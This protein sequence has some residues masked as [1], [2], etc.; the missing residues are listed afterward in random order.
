MKSGYKQGLIYLLVGFALFNTVWQIAAMIFN[1][2]ALP[3]PWKVY[4]GYKK[5]IDSGILMHTVYSLSRVAAGLTVSLIIGA[6]VGVA[7]GYSPRINKLLWPV[8]YLSYPVPKLALLPVI[9][10]FLGIGEAAKIAVIVLIIVFQLIISI[11]DAVQAIPDDKYDVF[12]SL[13]ASTGDMICHITLPAAVPAILSSLRVSAGIAISVLIVAETYGT[14]YGL[15]FYVIDSWMRADYVQ[16]YFG[17]FVLSIIGLTIFIL[18][19]LSEKYICR[20]KR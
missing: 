10:I 2:N 6:A 13:G 20:W 18:L 15:G 4:A 7:M 9:M 19:D 12:L 1:I 14:A 16:M 11:R 17:I 8:I 3:E 5:A